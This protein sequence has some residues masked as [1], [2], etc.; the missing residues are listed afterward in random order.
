[1]Q[2]TLYVYENANDTFHELI[3]A[4][5]KERSDWLY[6]IKLLQKD[7]LKSNIYSFERAPF[8]VGSSIRQ[9]EWLTV[10]RFD[11]YLLVS[12]PDE[13]YAVTD[14]QESK[15]IFP[16]SLDFPSPAQPSWS[17]ITRLSKDINRIWGFH[18]FKL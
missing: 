9:S 12:T 3:C 13:V 7:I 1:M 14:G 5:A 6:R 4:S 15:T 18:R 11:G 8:N 16:N 17:C 2:R 10:T